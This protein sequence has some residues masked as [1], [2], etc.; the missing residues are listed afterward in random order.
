MN[1]F[2]SL[3]TKLHMNFLFHIKDKYIYNTFMSCNSKRRRKKKLKNIIFWTMPNYFEQCLTFFLPKLAFSSINRWSCGNI[4]HFWSYVPIFIYL[5]M[6]MFISIL[7]FWME[8]KPKKKKRR[9]N[10]TLLGMNDM[11]YHTYNMIWI[12]E[13]EY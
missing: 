10:W 3:E 9:N 11:T 6:P 7:N 13:N 5:I 8:N 4:L 12:I 1:F 2:F